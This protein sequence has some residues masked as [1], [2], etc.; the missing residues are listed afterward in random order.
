MKKKTIYFNDKLFGMKI[1]FF[2]NNNKKKNC[3]F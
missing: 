1:L 3:F 2:V